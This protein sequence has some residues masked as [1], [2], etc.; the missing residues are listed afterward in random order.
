MR[1]FLEAL[2]DRQ[3]DTGAIARVRSCLA[4]LV[5]PDV[6]Y[7]VAAVIGPDA[8]PVARVMAAVLEAAGAPTGTMTRSL[9]DIRLSGAPLD[10]AL[11]AASGTETASAVYTLHETQPALG[12]V[13]RR[14]A[15]VL[16]G[17]IAFAK[18]GR[19]VALLLDEE[20]TGADPVHGPTP[21]L[22][23]ITRGPLETIQRALALVP[24]GRPAVAASLDDDA[25]DA[26]L[27]WERTSGSPLLLGDRDHEV[28]AG[29]GGP[30]AFAVRGEPYVSFEPV[31]G[32]DPIQMSCGLAAAL[33][34]G[35]L[36]IR[37][38][39]EWL[40]RGLDALRGPVGV[41]T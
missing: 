15:N 14:E 1:A 16:L 5:D 23:V 8:A 7:L 38:R 40:I 25:R 13:T 6:R 37:M 19:R 3:I 20:G 21:D 31:A 30:W 27:E 36:G 29:D 4:S 9:H 26:T 12:E 33:A 34:I 22:V 10:D 39:E 35:A 24:S 32:I 28:R 17:L 41:T 2:P 11:I 18:A